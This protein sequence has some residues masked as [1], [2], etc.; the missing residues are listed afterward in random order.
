MRGLLRLVALQSPSP[1][2]LSVSL[3][4]MAASR[5]WRPLTRPQSQSDAMRAMQ[6]S[7][8]CTGCTPRSSASTCT[9]VFAMAC[10]R[11]VFVPVFCQHN[12]TS[13]LDTL[14]R[15]RNHGTNLIP[16]QRWQSRNYFW[17]ESPASKSVEA[18]LAFQSDCSTTFN[19]THRARI[20]G[21]AVKT[22]P[23][24]SRANPGRLRGQASLWQSILSQEKGACDFA[25][26]ETLVSLPQISCSAG[27]DHAAICPGLGQTG[28]RGW[29]HRLNLDPAECTTDSKSMQRNWQQVPSTATCIT[30]QIGVNCAAR[31]DSNLAPFTPCSSTKGSAIQ[32]SSDRKHLAVNKHLKHGPQRED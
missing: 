6:S 7:H 31:W 20:L 9:G 3:S 22:M 28:G 11:D 16:H 24:H 17:G 4:P 14:R 30:H 5:C 21:P 15:T 18:W 32:T 12:V 23:P 25:T 1:S 10:G 2:R 13:L 27:C 26:V 19:S 29:D 8:G